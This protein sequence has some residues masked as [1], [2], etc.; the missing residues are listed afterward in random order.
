M[1]YVKDSMS[2]EVLVG[3]PQV[4]LSSVDPS[5]MYINPMVSE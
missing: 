1:G 2:E 3:D 4:S 5:D